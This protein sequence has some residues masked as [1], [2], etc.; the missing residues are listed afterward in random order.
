MSDET[1]IKA[2]VGT[3]PV[4]HD[5]TISA[6]DLQRASDEIDRERARRR[7]AAEEAQAAA[8]RKLGLWA[9]LRAWVRGRKR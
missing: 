9:R 4:A 2:Y 3:Y 8:A 7:L 6:V 1:P 5:I